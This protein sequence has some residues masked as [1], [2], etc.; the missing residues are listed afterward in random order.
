MT[1]AADLH[2]LQEIDLALDRGSARLAEIDET[3]GETEELLE[4]RGVMEEQKQIVDSLRSRQAELETDV[5]DARGKASGVEK[6]LYS[7]SVRNPK[8]LEDLQADATS[9]LGQT[10]KREDA[11][12]AVLV[13]VEEA[14]AQ[15]KEAQAAHSQVESRWREQQQAL[16]AE[17]AGLEPEVA[18][19]QEARA[20][21]T[22]GMDR[23]AMGLYQTLRERRA[24]QA[25]A[26]VERGMCQGCRITLPISVMQ[27]AR[28][29]QGLVQC[30]SCERILLVS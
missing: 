27:K 21:Q 16:E 4:A 5:E 9:L 18:Q 7:G 20:N 6:K 28:S 1:T 23:A 19:L 15:L 17:R 13:E 3:R 2:A 22:N 11:L 10:R 30:V 24:G 12:L 14:E 25:L 8:E 29:G 26:K